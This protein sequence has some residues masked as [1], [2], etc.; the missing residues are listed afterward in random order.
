MVQKKRLSRTK[1]SKSAAKGGAGGFREV[2]TGR[3][4]GDAEDCLVLAE[5]PTHGCQK[6]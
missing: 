2:E 1:E 4:Q 6:N 5:T 3:E